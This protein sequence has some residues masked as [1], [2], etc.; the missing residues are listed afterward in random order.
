MDYNLPTAIRKG[1]RE[2]AQ[3]SIEKYLSFDRLSDGNRAFISK[4][5][6]IVVPRT[7]KKLWMI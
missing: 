3:L 1:I 2:C 4:L 6:N 7:I 5:S